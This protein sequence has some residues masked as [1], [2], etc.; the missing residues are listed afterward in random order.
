[1]RI[2]L[3]F[4]F[5]F[6]LVLAAGSGSSAQ[7]PQ[8][9]GEKPTTF[10]APGDFGS[11]GPYSV[12]RQVLINPAPNTPAPISVFIPSNATFLNRVPAVF[13][14]HGYGGINYEFYENLLRQ[15]ASN[16]YIV[17][18][19]PYSPSLTA[20]HTERYDQLWTGFQTAVSQNPLII[21][22]TR[23]GFA[24]HS[25]GG[26]ATPEMA[27]RAVGAGWGT[28][29]L[30]MFPMAPWF[31]W[32][33]DMSQIPSTAKLIVQ[34][35]WDDDV[36]QHLIG[37][38]DV[39]N[40]LP[41]VVERK[42]QVIRAARSYCTL[43]AGHNV[44][45]NGAN[46]QNDGAINGYDAW[47]VWRRLHALADYTFRNSQPAREVAYGVDARMGRWRGVFG[48]RPIPPIETTNSPVVNS[49]TSPT[50]LWSAR[51]NFAQGSPC[52]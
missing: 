31:N 47:G 32:G 12:T 19:T 38:N 44:P 18:F 22:T 10:P 3:A 52:P 16:G 30:F 24:G 46:G 45:T 5:L 20:N 51:C 9:S 39:W 34:V 8:C 37:Q 28:N 40:R 35:Y 14:S 17:V 49:Q 4:T 11:T 29:G 36:N 43:N 50:F 13:F 33:T 2:A 48:S 23:V 7:I 15:L 41:Q 42:W 1:M 27:R 21:D 26:G 25:Y 6:V